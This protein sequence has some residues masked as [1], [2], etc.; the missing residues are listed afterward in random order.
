MSVWANFAPGSEE[1]ISGTD[2]KYGADMGV[3]FSMPLSGWTLSAEYGTD[4]V[5]DAS[6]TDDVTTMAVQ[7]GRVMEAGSGAR[8]D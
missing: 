5:T 4:A 6:D 1:K 8:W 7:M 3:G 2:A